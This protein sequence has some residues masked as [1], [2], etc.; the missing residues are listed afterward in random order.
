MTTKSWYWSGWLA[1]ALLPNCTS[2]E[3]TD[4]KGAPDQPFVESRPGIVQVSDNEG[5]VLGETETC[6][7]FR[8]A[9]VANAR[10]L[11]CESMGFLECPTLVQPLGAAV[12]IVYSKLSLESC[13][14][15][16]DAATDCGELMPGTC[17][18]TAHLEATSPECATGDASLAPDTSTSSDSPT[19]SPEG[20]AD[21]TVETTGSSGPPWM[22]D[23][24]PLSGDERDAGVWDGGPPADA[25]GS[26]SDASLLE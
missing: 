14:S 12:C 25:G 22:P 6:A 24:G 20:T 7:R 1:L 2:N 11:E 19:S 5:P 10:R 13:V 15:R 23:G 17:V 18:L 4:G 21:T 9:L 16:F 26:F 3:D 8:G